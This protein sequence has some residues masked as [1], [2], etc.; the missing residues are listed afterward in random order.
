NRQSKEHIP[1][2]DEYGYYQ[3]KQCSSKYCWCVSTSSGEQIKNTLTSSS[4]KDKLCC[5]TEFPANCRVRAVGCNTCVLQANILQCTERKGCANPSPPL[6][7]EY[8]IVKPQF[9][10]SIP[11]RIRILNLESSI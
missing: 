11:S 4:N 6:C 8:T 3:A 5:S 10:S 9:T 2:C 1:D 7:I